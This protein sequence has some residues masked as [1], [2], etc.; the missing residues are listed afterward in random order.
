MTDL[1]KTTDALN[2]AIEAQPTLATAVQTA[3]DNIKPYQDAL[4][5]ANKNETDN[6]ALVAD[7]K[8]QV[9]A[10]LTPSV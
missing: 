6:I 10:A 4:D 7:L 1:R 3:I 5:L 2:D 8:A 9:L